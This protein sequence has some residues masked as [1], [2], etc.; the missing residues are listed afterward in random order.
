MCN[1]ISL[2]CINLIYNALQNSCS[3]MLYRT[4]V[5]I[6]HRLHINGPWPMAINS[7]AHFVS[8]VWFLWIRNNNILKII[9]C[10]FCFYSFDFLFNS[11]SLPS[12][13]SRTF[14]LIYTYENTSHVDSEQINLFSSFLS[15]LSYNLTI[16]INFYLI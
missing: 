11:A 9:F 2:L 10:Q 14:S 4:E 13:S 7:Q 1:Y 3:V 12:F 15:T 8:L 6:F 5:L 16:H